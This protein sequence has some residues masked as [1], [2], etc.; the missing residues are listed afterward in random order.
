MNEEKQ[1]TFKCD[2]CK[3]DVE[4]SDDFCPGCGSLFSENIYCDN[5]PE[6]LANGVCI[7]CCVPYCSECAGFTKNLYLCEYHHNYEIYEGMVRVYGSNDLAQ[8][9]YV[10]SCLEEEG[11]NPFIFTRKASPISMGGPEYTLF[12]SS[13]DYDGHIIN[14]AKIMVPCQEVI[15]AEE[16]LRDL[17]LIE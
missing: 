7:I 8:V 16:I 11:L 3:S 10:K 15:D 12:T 14:E 5:H 6:Q 2:Y 1:K 17:K 13:G 9:D 4:D